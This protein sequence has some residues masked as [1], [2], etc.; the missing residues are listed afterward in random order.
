MKYFND[1]DSVYPSV[2]W[3]QCEM[4]SGTSSCDQTSEEVFPFTP[5][6]DSICYFMSHMYFSTQPPF[7]QQISY[8]REH[9]CDVIKKYGECLN[10]EKYYSKRHIAIN[11]PQNTPHPHPLW[12]HLSH[13]SCHFLKQ[14]WKSSFVSVFSCAVVVAR[15]PEWIKNFTFHSHFDFGEEPEVARC[16]IRWIRWMRTHCNI[17][18]SHKLPYQKRCV[19]RNVVMVEDETI[20][21]FLRSFSMHIVS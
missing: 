13:H 4:Q 6:N 20:C 18:I 15:C 3:C 12:T 1:N 10:K 5:R 17:F 19:T 14:F 11:P 9:L 8:N 2:E 16:Q 21:P 7:N